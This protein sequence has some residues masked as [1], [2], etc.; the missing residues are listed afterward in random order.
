[1]PIIL[2]RLN[3]MILGPKSSFKSKNRFVYGICY[4]LK[5]KKKIIHIVV[6]PSQNTKGLCQVDFV[7]YVLLRI[8]SFKVFD[9]NY[10]QILLVLLY[11]HCSIVM[12]CLIRVTESF[13]DFA[14]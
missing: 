13:R 9:L 8:W 11:H 1:M 5:L 10:T 12:S 7:L 6:C 2:A 4:H 3:F 14:A